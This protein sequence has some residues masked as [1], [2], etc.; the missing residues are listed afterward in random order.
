MADGVTCPEGTPPPAP[1]IQQPTAEAKVTVP[2]KDSDNQRARALA[3]TVARM[4]AEG[5]GVQKGEPLST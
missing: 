4:V 2:L 1:R 3:A 5:E